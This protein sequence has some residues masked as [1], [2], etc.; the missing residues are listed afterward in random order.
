MNEWPKRRGSM[1]T[2]MTTPAIVLICPI[3]RL[4]GRIIPKKVD[5]DWR[6]PDR[7]YTSSRHCLFFSASI[8]NLFSTDTYG[9]FAMEDDNV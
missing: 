4:S 3:R 8:E 6:D 9:F 2:G 7:L 5:L 1:L